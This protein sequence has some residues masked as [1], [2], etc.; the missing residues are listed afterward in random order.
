MQGMEGLPMEVSLFFCF[1][2]F[3]V[4]F[5]LIEAGWFCFHSNLV[6]RLAYQFFQSPLE[7]EDVEDIKDNLSH[8]IKDQKEVRQ[9]KAPPES[10]GGS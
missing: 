2:D 4:V 6:M 10:K 1:S 5:S 9:F 3:F 7:E 8:P